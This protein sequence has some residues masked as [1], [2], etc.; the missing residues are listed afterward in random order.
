MTDSTRLDAPSTAAAATDARAT[1]ARWWFVAVA[2]VVGAS[3]VIQTVL[4]VIGGTD[5]NSG[6]SGTGVSL[7]V[8]L[9]RLFSFFTV[10]SNI[11]VLVVSILL[12]I[13]PRRT[14]RWWEVARL[15]ALL[16]ITITGLVFAIVLAPLLHVTGW[17]AVAN[18][19]LHYV[20]PWAFVAGWLLLGPRHR[21]T[22]RTVDGAFILPVVWLVYIFIQGA[23]T[24]WYPYPFLDVT[25]LGLGP[26]IVN[27]ILV[28]LLAGVLAALYRLV[29]A[30]VPS[31]LE[32]RRDAA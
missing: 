10:E 21:F 16:A 3:L 11:V 1:A 4:V 17:A 9:W 12:A 8:R 5:A 19:G 24:D 7:P 32:R 6:E 22:W 13:D 23:F 25:V 31:L 15:N 14:G 18:A 29:D 20:G 27:A 28:L 2:L 26:A 30:R